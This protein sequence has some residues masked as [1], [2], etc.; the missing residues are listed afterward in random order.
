R[1]LKLSFMRRASSHEAFGRLN[2]QFA[3]A[4][5]RAAATDAVARLRAFKAQ[6]DRALDAWMKGRRD[7]CFPHGTWWM[8]IFHG[9]LC[10]PAP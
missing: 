4:G 3:A 6:Y 9:A 1:V 5:N 8:R 2:P 7:V 10:G